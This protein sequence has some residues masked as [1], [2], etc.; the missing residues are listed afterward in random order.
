MGSPRPARDARALLAARRQS[1]SPEP[2]TALPGLSV[3]QEAHGASWVGSERRGYTTRPAN[4]GH[5]ERGKE[6]GR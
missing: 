2:P 6:P 3:R 5:L 4:D 1:R